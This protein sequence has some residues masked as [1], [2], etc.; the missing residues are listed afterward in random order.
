[1]V[2]VVIM[3]TYNENANILPL[4]RALQEQFSSIPHEMHILVVDD[5]S[6]DGTGEL[7]KREL[8]RQGNLHL[9]T[10]E[11]QGLGV[12]YIK[13][14]EWAIHELHADVVLEMDADW[15]HKPEDVPRLIEALESGADFV[16]G[17]RYVYGGSIP[18]DWSILRKLNSRVGNIVA[19]Y[20]AGMPQIRDCTAGFRAIRVSLLSRMDVGSIKVQ[21][22]AFQVALL[23]RALAYG[24]KVMELPVEFVERA[25][26]KS[27]LGFGDIL[28]F[29]ANVW[30][31][32]FQRSQTFVKYS[33][34][35]MSGIFVNLGLFT[36]LLHLG[37]TRYLASPVAI[38]GS[39]IWNFMLN[40]YW[41]FG[42]RRTED[43]IQRKGCKFNVVS[44]LSL[45][46]AYGV[47]LA[48]SFAFPGWPLQIPQ[49]LGVVPAVLVNY[50]MNSYWTFRENR[51]MTLYPE[52]L[53]R[54][55]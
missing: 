32:R 1:M 23:H 28:E 5:N 18:N 10:G 38:E 37:F 11:K 20:V 27:K 15:S 54:G 50:F 35:G 25:H 19:R 33:I 13:G 30:W 36:L 12:A 17:S 26:G 6:P 2:I 42:W 55:Q 41:T 8:T 21:G 24:G 47:F 45:G 46:V 14:M 44:F 34:V 7:V 52:R 51:E 40:N 16:I 31:I 22:Y 49:L 9:L 53:H 3:P 43:T 39:I 48:F 29:V 4:I